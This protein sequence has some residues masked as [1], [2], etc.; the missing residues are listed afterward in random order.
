MKRLFAE[1][2]K[3][4]AL[5]FVLPHENTDWNKYLDEI[6]YSYREFIS[7]VSKFQNCFVLC[8]NLKKAEAIL[9]GIDN[10][11]F[12]EVP[13]N[14]TWI[15]DFGAIDVKSDNEIISYDFT[16]NAWG[17]KFDASL[18]NLVNKTLYNNKKLQGE[19]LNIPLILEGGSI[20]SNGEE[21]M[22]TT[23]KCLLEK[24]RNPHLTFP[25]IDT[26]LKELFGLK[27]IVWLENGYLKGDDTDSHV[28]TLARFIKPDTI[29]YTTCKDEK[30]EH[31]LEL[32]KMEE[33]LKNTGFNLL[34]LPLP[35]PIFYD[36]HRLPATYANFVFVNGALIVPTYNDK[37][38]DRVLNSLQNALSNH[39]IV[40][41]DARVFIREHGSLH[42]ATMNRYYGNRAK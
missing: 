9:D 12:F 10:V 29:A 26:K 36:K 2:E 20:D 3:Q 13:T 24:H 18:D 32:K 1:W 19:L 37:N 14:D 33:E 5:L 17:G 28:D 31:Y 11:A 34:P 27:K 41:V 30:D 35:K 16:F 6:L 38:D 42:C 25:Q 40:G 22:L 7:A 8:A 21:V 15:R 39:K 4:E 23:K